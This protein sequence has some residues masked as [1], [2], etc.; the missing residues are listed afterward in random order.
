[1]D[2]I[3]LQNP[4]ISLHKIIFLQHLAKSEAMTTT[5]RCALGT[6]PTYTQFSTVNNLVDV[7]MLLDTSVS[8][9]EGI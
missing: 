1:M 2:V 6:R 9:P 8:G 7:L 5:I 3:N 4:M